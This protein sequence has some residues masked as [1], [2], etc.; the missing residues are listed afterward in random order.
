VLGYDIEVAEVHAGLLVEVRSQGKPR[1]AH[2]LLI[3]ST[4]K[5]SD[6]TVVTADAGAFQN[7]TGVSVRTHR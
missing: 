6:R 2:V 1:G 7:L 4:A 5:A 3:A